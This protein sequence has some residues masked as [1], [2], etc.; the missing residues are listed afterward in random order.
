M[1]ADGEEEQL[2]DVQQERAFGLF[3]QYPHEC[4][5][6]YQRMIAIGVW[7]TLFLVLHNAYLITTML[8]CHERHCDR[9]ERFWLYWC[10]FRL[11]MVI[12]RPFWWM[13]AMS[14]YRIAMLAPSPQ[15]MTRRLIAT[16]NTWWFKMN[17]TFGTIFTLWLVAT[18]IMCYT[19]TFYCVFAK[20]L[21]RHCLWNLAN[22][23]AQR[24]A[25]IF[26][27]LYLTGT[28]MKRGISKIVLDHH[29]KIVEFKDEK[30]AQEELGPRKGMECSICFL[31][32][33]AGDRIRRLKCSHHFHEKC[34]DP[35][36]T[37]YQNRC[38]LCKYAVGSGEKPSGDEQK[39]T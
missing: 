25:S 21:W 7:P 27:L 12:P 20:S 11:L 26:F 6:L 16:H 34:I 15:Q 29:S 2:F 30:Q 32:Y 38:P 17:H 24:V 19:E 1:I 33:S 13:R 14:E 10:L 8:D 28:N 9:K 3:R 23:V 18:M 37:N 22:Q 4:C 36:L 5:V 35:W 31:T 39:V